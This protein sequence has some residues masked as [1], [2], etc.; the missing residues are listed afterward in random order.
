MYFSYKTKKNNYLIPDRGYS[1]FIDASGKH[2]RWVCDSEVEYLV[3][4]LECINNYEAPVPQDKPAMPAIER[5]WQYIKPA[6][7]PELSNNGGSYDHLTCIEKWVGWGK[8]DGLYLV[9]NH[10][11][12]SDFEEQGWH[13][14]TITEEEA[15][16]FITTFQPEPS[17]R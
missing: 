11:Y 16:K 3:K 6:E 13:E 9:E 1:R 12:N 14:T 4:V 17:I 15:E 5:V 10:L 7:F 2:L 8:A